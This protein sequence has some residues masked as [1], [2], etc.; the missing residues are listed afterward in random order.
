MSRSTD[1]GQHLWQRPLPGGDATVLCGAGSVVDEL[2]ALAQRTQQC[3]DCGVGGIARARLD[4][5]D[6]ALGNTRK[7]RQVPLRE[8]ALEAAR[9]Q[10]AGKPELLAEQLQLT[11]GPRTLVPSLLLDIRNQ[12]T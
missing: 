11:D 10:L 1:I 7:P 2:Y 4:A 3:D 6:L 9:D 5:G 8:L 12:W